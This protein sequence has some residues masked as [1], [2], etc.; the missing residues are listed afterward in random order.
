MPGVS[1]EAKHRYGQALDCLGDYLTRVPQ[2]LDRESV[3]EH[4]RSLRQIL[5][6]LN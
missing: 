3:E 2:A 1:A 6:D 5:A 4:V